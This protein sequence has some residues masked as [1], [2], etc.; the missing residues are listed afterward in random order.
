[1]YNRI[2][3]ELIINPGESTLIHT[4][5]SIELSSGTQAQIPPRSGLSLKHQVRAILYSLE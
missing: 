1:M 2:F 5:I 4:G 3:D